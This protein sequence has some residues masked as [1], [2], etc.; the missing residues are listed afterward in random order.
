M[1]NF[2]I[3]MVLGLA[4]LPAQAQL[5]GCQYTTGTLPL[6]KVRSTASGT[7]I[8]GCINDSFD[9]LSSSAAITSTSAVTMAD[10]LMVHRIS[11][12]ATGTVGV[13]MSSYTWFTS[14]AAVVAGG[15]FAVTYGT[16]FGSTTIRDQLTVIGTS[17]VK[18]GAFSVA[19][20]TFTVL[21]GRIGIGTGTPV[22]ILDVQ[23]GLGKYAYLGGNANG[24]RGIKIGQ[25]SGGF[26]HMQ[27]FERVAL[28]AADMSLQVEGGNVGIGTLN[29]CSTCTLHVAGNTSV[30]GTAQTLNLIV[31]GDLTS[32][33]TGFQS[34]IAG[35]NV[36]NTSFG[37]CWSSTATITIESGATGMV[38]LAF[39]GAVSHGTAGQAVTGSFSVDGVL[40]P[41]SPGNTSDTNAVGGQNQ[42]YAMTY[43]AT[44]LSA[45]T[46]NFCVKLRVDAGTGVVSN[47]NSFSAFRV[48]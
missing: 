48:R 5:A 1:I 40:S 42:S 35:S 9:R 6:S 47:Y 33:A 26:A 15:G 36:T 18:G 25:T 21:N 37:P 20:A 28:G 32:N 34:T 10:W 44:G 38:F 45:G 43:L 41:I 16:D 24:H 23:D 11:G 3:A 39:T 19:S 17:T 27:A 8:F 2:I 7:Q 13:Q 4:A 30:T 12:L 22:A 29:P 14:S 46:H 31:T